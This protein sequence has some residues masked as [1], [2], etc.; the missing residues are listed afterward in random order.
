[1]EEV[2]VSGDGYLSGRHPLAGVARD[3]CASAHHCPPGAHIG[4]VA[5]GLHWEQAIRADERVAAEEDLG[6]FGPRDWPDGTPE[7]DRIQHGTS[8]G[9]R[10]HRRADI[11]ACAD[12]LR[13]AAEYAQDKRNRARRTEAVA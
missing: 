1:M 11:P 2:V 5:C 12:C 9:Y 4:G 6:D 10:Q 7:E 3:M 13:A 8:A